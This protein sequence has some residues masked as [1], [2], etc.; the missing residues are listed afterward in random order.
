MAKLKTTPHPHPRTPKKKKGVTVGRK[1]IPKREG[2]V[3]TAAGNG[4]DSH[5]TKRRSRATTRNVI[6]RGSGLALTERLQAEFLAAYQ[7]VGTIEGACRVAEVGRRTHYDWIDRDPAYAARFCG[8]R[9]RRRG[10]RCGSQLR[11]E[12]STA[13]TSRSFI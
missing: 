5:G 1:V 2:L 9:T 6:G 8:R 13:T 3:R 12:V 7:G 11:A 10:R 4:R